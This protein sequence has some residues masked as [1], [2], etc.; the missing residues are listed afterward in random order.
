MGVGSNDKRD[1][2]YYKAK[3]MGYRARSAFKLID[4]D[5]D[6]KILEN[7]R[8]IVD[9]CAA[10]GSWSQVLC[11][12]TK[13]RIVAVDVQEIAPID[14]ATCLKAD[15]TS[16]QCLTDIRKIFEGEEADLVICDGAPDITGIH[17]L[18]E[19]L[20]VELLKAALSISTS[21]SKVSGVFIGKCFRGEFTRFLIHHFKKFYDA[22]DVVKPKS[23]RG[24]SLECFLVCRGMKRTSLNPE[25]LDV[26]CDPPGFEVKECGGGLNPDFSIGSAESF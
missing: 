3:S 18:D 2:Y 21:L 16:P 7:A 10:P 25:E 20:Q 22:V 13:A 14:G 23:S 4:I 19:Y 11:E 6:F 17:D 24:A 8:N 9:L 26:Y 5:N 1:I 15:I 12:R